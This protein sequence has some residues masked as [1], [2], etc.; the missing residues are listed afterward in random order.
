MRGFTLVE[1]LVVIGIIALLIAILLPAL[2]KARQQAVM[3]RC[4]SNLHQI[5]MALQMYAGDNKGYY[6]PSYGYNGN[7]LFWTGTNNVVHHLG[8]LLGDWKYLAGWI[9]PANSKY[10]PNRDSL[11]CPGLGDNNDIYSDSYS[12]LRFCGYSYCVPKSRYYS[13]GS[14]LAFKMRQYIPKDGVAD[15]FSANHLRWQAVVACYMQVSVQV[16]VNPPPPLPQ[17][18]QGKGVNVLYFD[19]SVRW[20]PRPQRLGVGMG[21]NLYNLYGPVAG[22]PTTNLI[23]SKRV[24]GWPDDPK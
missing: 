7:E 24:P 13:G 4:Q 9:I 10:I 1:L 11:T 23:P 16:P 14:W 2:N 3:V 12:Q 20:V 17:P 15:V 19:A 18:H 6:P 22:S 8:M 5:G 21:F